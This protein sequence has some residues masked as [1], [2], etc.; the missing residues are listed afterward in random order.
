MEH[1]KWFERV[2]GGDS[3]LN[4]SKTA[5]PRLNNATLSRQLNKGQISSENVIAIARGYGQ[6]P[7]EAL[8]QTGYLTPEEAS[9]M[10]REALAELLTDQEVIRVLAYRIN[11]DEDAWKGTFTEVVEESQG[12]SQPS[13]QEERGHISA[14]HLYVTP[15]SYDDDTPGEEDLPY[16]ADSSPDEPMPGD[17]DYSDGP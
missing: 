4:A 16:A 3:A 15:D 1:G 11:E 8:A 7:V 14:P 9:G 2:T 17:D 10:P 13:S 12:G 5:K 6:S